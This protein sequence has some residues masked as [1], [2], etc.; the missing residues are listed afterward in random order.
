[1]SIVW[2]CLDFDLSMCIFG[3]IIKIDLDRPALENDDCVVKL[4]VLVYETFSCMDHKT[5]NCK[6]SK[7]RHLTFLGNKEIV[8]KVENSNLARI[9]LRGFEIIV[10]DQV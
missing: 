1:M 6:N 7:V 10:V 5:L 8:N 9:D 4:W 3:H 2:L